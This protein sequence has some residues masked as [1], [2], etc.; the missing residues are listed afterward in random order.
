MAKTAP[1]AAFLLYMYT[2]YGVSAD[3]TG[4]FCKKELI[5]DCVY[6]RFCQFHSLIVHVIP[7][8][9]QHL[10][11]DIEKNAFSHKF[12]FVFPVISSFEFVK[13]SANPYQKNFSLSPQVRH[14]SRT[15]RTNISSVRMTK[16]SISNLTAFCSRSSRSSSW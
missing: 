13:I 6:S 12:P 11:S 16:G 5:S 4:G 14:V 2:K 9:F 10:L 1:S 7:P 3:T 15:S 8:A